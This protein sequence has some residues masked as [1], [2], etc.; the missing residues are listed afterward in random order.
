MYKYILLLFLAFPLGAFAQ[1][2]VSD[3]ILEGYAQAEASSRAATTANTVKQLGEAYKQTTELSKTADFLKKSYDRLHEVNVFITNLS[4]L[5]RLIEKQEKLISQTKEI[6]TDL[7]TSKLY[8]LEEVNT[9]HRSF[10]KMI[11]TTNDIVEMLD[12]ILKPKT[13]MSDGERMMLLRQMEEDFKERQCMMDK[14][15]WEY[16]RIRN[17]RLLNDTLKKMHAN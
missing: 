9:L 7:E 2:V 6:V 8:T 17:Q 15:I 5:E 11:A 3:P 13:N 1:L 10:T 16:R 12:I 14:T 4:R